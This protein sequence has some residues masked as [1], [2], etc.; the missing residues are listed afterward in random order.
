M[1]NK[2]YKVYVAHPYNNESS[3]KELVE[4]KIKSLIPKNPN[5]TYMSPIHAFGF[6]YESVD[7]MDGMEYCFDLLDSCDVALFCD[8]WKN[9]KGCNLEMKYCL[10]NGIPF[11]TESYK[12]KDTITEKLIST[13]LVNCALETVR[14]NGYIAIK[15]TEKMKRDANECEV[16]N[17]KD[18]TDCHC[19]LCLLEQ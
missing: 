14:N 9:S 17:D 6:T 10:D 13:T 5:I 8:G 2:R 19:N 12:N 18:C 4:S 16:E 7:Y 3:N 15:M 11:V 1:R